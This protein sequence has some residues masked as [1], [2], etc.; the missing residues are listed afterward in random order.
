LRAYGGRVPGQDVGGG[1]GDEDGQTMCSQAQH[2][3][4]SLLLGAWPLVLS[5]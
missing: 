4:A 3:P 1:G 5:V 2:Q